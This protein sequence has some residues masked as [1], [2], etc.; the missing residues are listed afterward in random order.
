M[1][2]PGDIS[3]E[4]RARLNRLF[5]N[6]PSSDTLVDLLLPSY[7]ATSEESGQIRGMYERLQDCLR[8]SLVPEEFHEA[9]ELLLKFKKAI[10]QL[11]TIE[12]YEAQRPGWNLAAVTFRKMTNKHL[13]RM[14]VTVCA[15]IPESVFM[16]HLP[17]LF[18]AGI[19]MPEW[20]FYHLDIALQRLDYVN[21]QTEAGSRTLIDQLFF[22]IMDHSDA[23]RN[24]VFLLPELVLS[25][26]RDGSLPVYIE[27][28][29]EKKVT[30]I[31][32]ITDYETIKA[33]KKINNKLDIM[34]FPGGRF[35]VAEAKGVGNLEDWLKQV[36]AQALAVSAL[37][38]N[39]PC[40]SFTLTNGTHWIFGVL[41]TSASTRVVHHSEPIHFSSG[42][43]K[44]FM[45]ALFIW[46]SL[47]PLKF[48]LAELTG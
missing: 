39:L 31:T 36:I 17:Q 2:A 18:N 48:V 27:N 7:G 33:G 43:P 25:E 22:C 13:V 9:Q 3:D 26:S 1:D 23:T 28:E 30:L 35:L 12:E 20:D 21:L 8:N 14:G 46:A 45:D 24:L 37:V 6:K 10:Q 47:P 44:R 15:A 5:A 4:L 38:P 11:S 19:T 32:G 41:D 29:K 40:I 34:A 16:E 42:D